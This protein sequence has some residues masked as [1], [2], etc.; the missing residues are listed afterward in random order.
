MAVLISSRVWDVATDTT[1][2][3]LLSLS[4]TF[5]LKSKGRQ[6]AIC[7]SLV[8]NGVSCCT[9]TKSD[10]AEVQGCIWTR[11][12]HDVWVRLRTGLPGFDS[13]EGQ[14]VLFYWRAPDQ[15]WDT[16]RILYNGHRRLCS[17][18]QSGRSVKVTT[19]LHLVPGLLWV[20]LYLR[21]T[22]R[23]HDV[24]LN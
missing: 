18:G 6:L 17:W 7:G 12:S 11:M 2:R 13:Q 15:L 24:V 4:L 1:R 22:I 23:L 16:L 5:I 9:S 8:A 3:M 14:Y 10:K 21:V 19:H 20:E